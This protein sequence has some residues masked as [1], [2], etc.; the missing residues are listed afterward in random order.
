[1]NEQV[2]QSLLEVK[3]KGFSDKA[4]EIVVNSPLIKL[5]EESENLKKQSD[6]N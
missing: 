6:C 5:V 1:M 4:R 3:L 2:E